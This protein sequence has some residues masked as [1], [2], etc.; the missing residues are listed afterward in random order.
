MRR[1]RRE[2]QPRDGFLLVTPDLAAAA[3]LRRLAAAGW[4][5]PGLSFTDAY[6]EAM[7]GF[8]TTGATVL[9]GLETLPVSVNVWRCLLVLVGGMGIIVL[10]VAILPL[11]GVGG[12]QLF[13]SETAGP[14]EGPE[15]DAAHRRD[16]ARLVGRLLRDCRRLLPGLPLG[17]H[18]LDR[19][20]H[21]HVLDD[22][23]GRLRRL[24]RQLRALRTRRS[25]RP[26]PMVFM[27][28]AG[29]NFALYFLVWKKRSPAVL[30]HDLEVRM[31]VPLVLASVL[32]G[33]GLPVRQRGLPELRD[34]AAPLRLQRRV[35]GHHHRLRDASTT[36]NGRSSRRC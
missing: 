3:G 35:G 16:G 18:E 7:S 30:W 34:R 14:D 12:A 13:K 26:W 19:C 29:I 25:S 8:T 15:A 6:F 11:L 23:A 2:L 1:F 36:R 24:R 10:V 33:G 31:Y 9:T 20:L 17:R 27:L 32:A 21:A 4:A 22:G 28:L 5:M